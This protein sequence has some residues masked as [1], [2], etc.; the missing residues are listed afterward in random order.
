MNEPDTQLGSAWSAWPLEREVVI[1]RVVGADRE[2]AFRAWTD[3]AQIVA[4]FGPEG[5]TIETHEIDIR[6]GGLWRFDMVA[7][8]GT[9]YGSRM[10]FLRVVSPSLIEVS[11]GKDNDDDPDRFRMLVTFDAQDN[12]KTVVTLRQMHPT[13]ARRAAVIAFGAV[14]YGAQTLDKLARHVAA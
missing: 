7:P 13:A 14:E 12:G 4:W 10:A 2:T 8:D 3:P 5:F 1:A 11:H 6:P 9:R